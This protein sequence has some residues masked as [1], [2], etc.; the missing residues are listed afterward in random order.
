MMAQ[1]LAQDAETGGL[2]LPTPDMDGDALFKLGLMYSAGQGGCPL[3]RVSAHMIFNLAAMKGA[4]E[5]R[6]YRREMS[7]EM[8]REEISEAQRAARRWIDAGTVTL[9]A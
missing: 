3:D 2:P 6:D 1:E 8:D 5:A 7:M 9:A 4:I